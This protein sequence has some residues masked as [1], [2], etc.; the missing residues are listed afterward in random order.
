MY[1]GS[2]SNCIAVYLLNF[3]SLH[4]KSK[5]GTKRTSSDTRD[6]AP[7]SWFF[8]GILCHN[9]VDTC[10]C[11]GGTRYAHLHTRRSWKWRQQVSPKHWYIS[12]RLHSITSQKS[13][14]IVFTP[15][16]IQCIITQRFYKFWTVIQ[17]LKGVIFNKQIS[18]HPSFIFFKK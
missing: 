6:I 9:P 13:V 5:V 10:Q 17:V 16:L 12:T 14:S 4:L 3:D 15:S 7:L 1:P 18:G 8:S 11:F 2:K